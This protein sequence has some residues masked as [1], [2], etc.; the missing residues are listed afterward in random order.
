MKK[1]AI[2]VRPIRGECYRC[3]RGLD[4]PG[5]GPGDPAF[6][7]HLTAEGHRES[8]QEEEEPEENP[9]T[10]EVIPTSCRDC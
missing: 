3:G 10:A 9:Q 8:E 5:H 6:L 1:E 4:Q 7:V 2:V